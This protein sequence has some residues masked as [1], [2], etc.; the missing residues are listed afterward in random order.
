MQE[1]LYFLVFFVENSSKGLDRDAVLFAALEVVVVVDS[2]IISSPPKSSRL[3][4][5]AHTVLR[6]ALEVYRCD[7]RCFNSRRQSSSQQRSD[8]VRCC[9][10]QLMGV[11]YVALHTCALYGVNVEAGITRSW[12]LPRLLLLLTGGGEEEET[13]GGSSSKVNGNIPS[14]YVKR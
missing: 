14:G 12:L 3:S 7:T 4:N 13:G 6:G 1:K 2:P 5:L 10:K 11:S 8:P 9:N